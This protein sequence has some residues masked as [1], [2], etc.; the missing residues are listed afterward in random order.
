[1]NTQLTNPAGICWASSHRKQPTLLPHALVFNHFDERLVDDN[2]QDAAVYRLTCPK[3]F[4][5][6]SRGLANGKMS[7]SSWK[8]S[9]CDGFGTWKTARIRTPNKGTQSRVTGMQ[10]NAPKQ[11]HCGERSTSGHNIGVQRVFVGTSN[12]VPAYEWQ[13]YAV[14]THPQDWF[15]RP[16][17]TI[18]IHHYRAVVGIMP[19][20]MPLNSFTRGAPRGPTQGSL[21]P[22]TA[23][24]ATRTRPTSEIAM[25]PASQGTELWFFDV[26]SRWKCIEC[27]YFR[28]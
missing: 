18:C 8:W 7:T 17:K 23:R 5:T 2:F 1:M 24:P 28:I 25:L 6:F 16:Q 20:L 19:H 10:W 9:F 3:A 26:L 4:L 21:P 12:R 15:N 22:K 11:S 27:Y 14:L 13:W